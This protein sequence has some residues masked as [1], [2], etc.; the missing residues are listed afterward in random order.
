MRTLALLTFAL[1]AC[2]GGTDTS[3]AGDAGG[4]VQ[5][6]HK[7]IEASVHDAAEE[8]AAVKVPFNR[9]TP[10]QGVVLS[11]MQLRALYVGSGQ[12]VPKNFDTLL[13][14]M[15]TSTNYWSILAQY[16]VGYGSFI[17]GVAV[18]STTFFQP[19]DI[20]GGFIDSWT[21]ESRIKTAIAALP[22]PE[23]GAANAYIVF[24]PSGVNVNLGGGDTCS[25]ALGYHS[26]DGIE[27]Y[28]VIPACG[29]FPVT[30]THEIAEMVTD[31]IPSAGWYSDADIDPAGGEVG[32][33]CNF[34]VNFDGYYVTELW[35]NAD[36][37]CEPQ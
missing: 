11:S 31:P 7:P 15:V 4:D 14:W 6:G 17:D 32:D 13:T 24:L 10:H 37:D 3:D 5:Y 23:S 18:D 33:L 22:A 28:S 27:P 2:G 19:N 20:Q 1:C 16:G 12:N 34:P 36:G 30:V 35:S 26:H 29:A 21:L 8:E 9:M 25:W